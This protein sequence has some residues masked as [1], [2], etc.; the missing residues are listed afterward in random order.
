LVAE[1]AT[2]QET[3]RRSSDSRSFGPSV[4][5]LRDQVRFEA[6]TRQ[7]EAIHTSLCPIERAIIQTPVC[8][9]AGLGVKARHAAYVV[10][11]YWEAPIER[12][13]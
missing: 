13:D 9:I 3:N 10:S 1:L 5:R 4:E 8:T 2:V 7:L 6:Q 11:E 12:I